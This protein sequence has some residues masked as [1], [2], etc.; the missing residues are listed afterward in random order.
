MYNR[1]VIFIAGILMLVSIVSPVLAMPLI[2]I[3]GISLHPPDS[4]LLGDSIAH[5][6]QQNGYQLQI[7]GYT[8]TKYI[9][10]NSTLLFLD[11]Q[12]K[13][14]E[15]REGTRHLILMRELYPYTE[16]NPDNFWYPGWTPSIVNGMPVRGASPI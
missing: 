16:F 15:S 2:D 1:N 5:T 7:T 4:Y 11:T 8:E 9:Q 6:G 10:Y 3:P 12:Y 13:N 14:G